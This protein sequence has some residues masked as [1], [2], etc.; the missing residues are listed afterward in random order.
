M[1]AENT[2][3]PA[4]PLGQSAVPEAAPRSAAL[5]G[6]LFRK[7]VLLFV[8]LVGAALVISG[9]VDFWFDYEGNK[10]AL[11]D[12]QQEKANAAAQRIEEFFGEIERQ[13]GWTTHAEWSAAPLDQRRFDY[14][15]LLAQVPA[16][17]EISELDGAGKEQ[18]KVSRVAIDVVG[19]G[20]DYSLSPAF[21]EARAH[22][23]W[24]SPVYFRKQSEP[25]ITL[26][27]ADVG[28][29]AGVTVAQVNLKLI[30]GVI[31][32]LKIGQGGYAYVVDGKGK[33]IAHPDIS[34]VLRDTDYSH[35]PQVAA[36]LHRA[37]GPAVSVA[38]NGEGVAVL[39][40]HAAIAPL[41]W[42]VFVE[43]PLH[44]A[45]APLY[46]TALRSA[47]LLVLALAGATLAALFLARRM[48]GPIRAMQEGAARIGAGELDRRLDIHTGDELEALAQQFNRMAGDLQTSYARLEQKVEERTAELSQSLEYQTATSDVL[49]VISRSTFDLQPVL[50]SVVETAIRL[51]HADQAV[52]FRNEGGEYRW[53]AGRGNTPEYEE[54]ERELSFRP[55]PGSLVGRTASERRTV[56][57][58]DTQAD[59]SYELKED[60]RVGGVRTLLGVPLLRQGEVI[61]VIG[62]ARQRVESFT[63]KQIQLVTTFAD[64]AVI[65][66]E[67]ARLISETR[68]ALEQ[69]TATADVLGVINSSP[70]DLAPVFDAML[71]KAIR[72]CEGVQGTLWTFVS[73][74]I[75]LTASRGLKRKFV[76][77][78][79]TER[80]GQNPGEQDPVRRIMRGERLIQVL[81][82][83]TDLTHGAVFRAAAE[84]G[85]VRTIMVVGLFK[86]A[87]PLGAFVIS[88]REVHAFTDKQIA[89]LQNFAAQ[90][91]IAMENARLINETRHARDAAETAL[92][93]LKTAQASLI[94]AE[95]MA[96]LGQLT[97]GIAHEIKN[98]LN[99]VNNFAGLSVE[100]LD[101]LKEVAE[102]AIATLDEDKREEIEE[103]IALL[104]GN[105][106]KIA[107]HG[108]RA[109]NIVKSMLEHSRGVSGERRD[110]D[111][112]ALVEEALNLAYHG[113][114]AQDPN[115]NITLE[116]DFDPAAK[117]IELVPQD[118]TRVFLNLFGNGFYA[119]NK[120]AHTDGGPGFRP[121][122]KVTTH[123]SGDAFEIRVRDNGSG[124]PPEIRNKLFQPFFTTKPTGEGTGLG[125]SITYDIVTQQHGGT[126]AVDSEPGAFTEFTIR[127][128][129]T[130]KASPA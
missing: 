82:L 64:Q 114:R 80:E 21:I 17:T 68:E 16:I 116:R 65:A 110:V 120:R 12:V 129:R 91:V 117:P 55:G 4:L 35:L 78:L 27:I 2:G 47:V 101:E 113:A 90:A 42:L 52:I 111:L 49:K 84:L 102:P 97:A 76:E 54:I 46:G 53:A 118:V 32:A 41:G 87:V 108:R 9:G 67:N 14:V 86:D 57:I 98:P 20:K 61:G 28:R 44:E 95:K 25:Y 63:D 31:T 10:A 29:D 26:A 126:I 19:S 112:N 74:Q 48:A 121:I 11:I 60:A 104:T 88:R 70:G 124:I 15:R 105:L 3:L 79:R 115:F 93:E 107:E 40:A 58:A 123:D 7:Y 59:P 36:A 77:M 37:A 23:I 72:L 69:Q 81:D 38:R 33:L 18:L 109:D 119:A 100:L 94:Q 62:L 99:F 122:L 5:R 128:P 56:Q 83:T 39:S 130:Q 96:S 24:F 8:G 125:L 103:A 50:D 73:E 45:F 51:C 92:G 6:R 71:E 30:W 43:L 75:V 89:L 34:L 13:I 22:K 85:G 66:M 106:E 1:S 127:L